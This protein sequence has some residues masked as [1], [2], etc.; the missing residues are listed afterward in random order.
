M[1]QPADLGLVCVSH[2]RHR[3]DVLDRQPTCY[4]LLM[5]FDPSRDIEAVCHALERVYGNP[6]HGNKSDPLDELVYIILSTRT[7]D[8]SYRRR[9]DELKA[10]F[11]SWDAVSPR[12]QA[13]IEAI[14]QPGGLAM[15]KAAVIVEILNVLRDRFGSTTLE[16]L[17]CMPDAD[18]E[19][20]LVS[21]PGVSTK[22]AKCVMMY[23]MD[24]QV[25][26]V[27]VH[28]HRV[29]A[30]LGFSVKRRPDTSQE[31]IEGAVPRQL[32]YGFH[33][34]AVAH[35]RAV[36]LSRAPR[37]EMCCISQWCDYLQTRKDRECSQTATGVQ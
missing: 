25:L 14:L 32:R 7:R 30:R 29:A 22:V 16:P 12:D 28:V 18:V 3:Y 23:S 26:P 24:R 35:G 31:L 9:Y 13:R 19:Q 21:L 34:N 37:C 20:L 11:P 15:L 27:D 2:R 6:S 36:C 33:I 8:A 4:A 5:V 17:R 1:A 10:A